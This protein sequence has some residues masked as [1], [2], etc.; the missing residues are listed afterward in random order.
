MSLNYI[1]LPAFSFNLSGFK[2]GRGGGD[3]GGKF[4]VFKINPGYYI[5][6]NSAFEKLKVFC[7]N[8][9]SLKNVF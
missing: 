9:K 8:L 1:Y 5:L 2:G 4:Q 6:S 7:F 3:R